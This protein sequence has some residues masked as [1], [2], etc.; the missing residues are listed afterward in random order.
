MELLSFMMG[1]LAVNSAG[2]WIRS[3]P[4]WCSSWHLSFEVF[5]HN[6]W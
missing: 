2:S 4:G 6:C 1:N 3:H 5:A